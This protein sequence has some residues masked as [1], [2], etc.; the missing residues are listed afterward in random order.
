[1]ASRLHTATSLAP[2][3]YAD[4]VTTHPP[5]TATHRTHCPPPAART[6]RAA[7][8]RRRSHWTTQPPAC[9]AKRASPATA[10]QHTAPSCGRKRENRVIASG[11]L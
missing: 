9:P 8:R 5:A 7:A 4:P 3:P 6:V 2:T 10:T 1:M 11:I